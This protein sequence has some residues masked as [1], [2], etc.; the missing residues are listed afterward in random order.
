MSSDDTNNNNESS[1]G[2]AGNST[3]PATTP[4][5]VPVPTTSNA[6]AQYPQL[7]DKGDFAIVKWL[8]GFEPHNLP[9]SLSSAFRLGPLQDKLKI[10]KPIV[11][12]AN[13]SCD[14]KSAYSTIDDPNDIYGPTLGGRRRASD[15]KRTYPRNFTSAEKKRFELLQDE[16]HN[17]RWQN[18]LV[19]G[20]DPAT[21][22]TMVGAL[23]DKNMRVF[24]PPPLFTL[25]PRMIV[26]D[27]EKRMK[28]KATIMG[29]LDG[30]A[31]QA[32]K[33][34]L[35]DLDR[36]IAETQKG[37]NSNNNK[38]K[39]AKKKAKKKAA[40]AAAK[41]KT[42]NLSTTGDS[43]A[44][45]QQSQQQ[46]PP[47]PLSKSTPPP[48]T[49]T[50]NKTETVEEKRRRI[51]FAVAE[52]RRKQNEAEQLKLQQQQKE[53]EQQQKGKEEGNDSGQLVG[54]RPSS[55]GPLSP[56]QMK[57]LREQKQKQVKTLLENY[58][59]KD[60]QIIRE[61]LERTGLNEEDVTKD[62]TSATEKD[63]KGMPYA[64]C[65]DFCKTA[66]FPTFAEAALHEVSAM[67]RLINCVYLLLNPP[68][69]LLLFRTHAFV[70][71][72]FV[73]IHTIRPHAMKDQRLK[74]RWNQ[75]INSD[76][77]SAMV[78]PVMKSSEYDRSRS[79]LL[80]RVLFQQ[81]KLIFT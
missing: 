69:I 9:E 18:L 8:A 32:E 74:R 14:F 73:I 44:T 38:G 37:G 33:E 78:I 34:L 29:Y 53:K 27:E 72:L 4:N 39:N 15:G 63:G 17:Q 57:Y 64:W 52:A 50:T 24:S 51:E 80:Q 36:E 42:E 5:N 19:L 60:R 54:T 55:P 28:M 11:W 45:S 25:S 13:L 81:Y 46:P 21:A 41:K 77:K 26:T 49:T 7:E 67:I 6:P 68:A 40:A 47:P 16:Y 3:T 12:L 58:D 61:A 75:Q 62:V 56:D 70:L 31:K 2:A 66:T 48:V 30:L 35:E 22:A 43:S 20:Y 65:C 59:E 23:R 1:G 79:V 10:T 76:I 71:I